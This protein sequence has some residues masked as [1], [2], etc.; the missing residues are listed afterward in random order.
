[1]AVKELA[2]TVILQSIED[3]WDKEQKASCSTFFC[4]QGFSF[5]AD[6]AKINIS[7][8]RKILSMILNSI[9]RGD[10]FYQGN[11]GFILYCPVCKPKPMKAE[12]Q[13]SA[14]N[15]SKEDVWDTQT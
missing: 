5:W 12:K 3:L 11:T 9:N 6:A 4:G 7:D 1:M 2:E 13:S 14:Q 10:H 8:R 15:L